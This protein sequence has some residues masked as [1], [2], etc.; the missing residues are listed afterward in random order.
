MDTTSLSGQA[1][2]DYRILRSAIKNEIFNFED[3]GTY[4][5]N[6]MTYAGATDLSIYIKRDFAPLET[7]V[8]S[9]IAIEKDIPKVFVAAKQNLLDSLPKP[10]IETAIQIAQGSA[11]FWGGDMKIALKDVKNDIKRCFSQFS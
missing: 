2:Y 3:M 11:A 8:R 5:K 10:Y 4:D 6:P 1:F 9:I 7:R